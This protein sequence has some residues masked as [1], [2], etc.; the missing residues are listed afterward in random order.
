MASRLTPRR[1]PNT[2]LLPATPPLPS[3]PSCTLPSQRQ[4][5]LDKER[6]DGRQERS[7]SIVPTTTMP[8]I[9]LPRFAPPLAVSN[10]FPHN[11]SPIIHCM[12]H[13]PT[14]LFSLN[15]LPSLPLLRC[16]DDYYPNLPNSHS[17]HIVDCAFNSLLLSCVSTPDWDMFTTTSPSSPTH[18]HALTRA[19]SGGPVYFSDP[20]DKTPAPDYDTLRAASGGGP[21]VGPLLPVRER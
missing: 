2:P 11:P 4:V 7:D 13:S 21:C 6:S 9:F 1:S 10:S 17:N 3:R 15:T 19:V 20:P 18:L 16:S 5:R 8:N 14:I 12:C